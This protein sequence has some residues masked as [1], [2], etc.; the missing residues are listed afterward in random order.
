MPTKLPSSFAALAGALRKLLGRFDADSVT[1]QRALVRAL[2]V[3]PLP[4]GAALV[5]YHD[6]LLFLAAHPFD[7]AMAHDVER[8]M[9]RIERFLKSQPRGQAPVKAWEDQGMPWVD[10]VT[11]FSHDTTRW[12]LTHPMLDVGIECIDEPRASYNDVLAITLP[13]LERPLTTVGHERSDLLKALGVAPRDELRFVVDELARLDAQPLAK[14]H[15]HDAL[16]IFLRI[17]PRSAAFSKARNRL[18][19]GPQGLVHQRD[20]LRSFDVRALLDTPLPEPRAM[21]PAARDEVIRVL[22]DTMTLT[23]RETDPCTYLEPA[24]LRVWDLERGLAVAFFGMQPQRQMPLESYVGF[25]L[26]KNGLPVAYGGSWVFGARADFGMNIFEPYRGG[27]SGFMMAQL[28]RC[29]RQAFG[30]DYFE[31]DAHQFGLDNPDG[32][33]SGAYWFY[34]RHGFRSIDSALARLAEQEKR[35]ID[36]RPGYRSSEK[37]LLRFTGSNV[38]LRLGSA[39]TLPVGVHDIAAKVTAMIRRDHEG[40]RAKAEAACLA[41]LCREAGCAPPRDDGPDA[42]A[43]SQAALAACATRCGDQET[44]RLW[45]ASAAAK[46]KDLFAYQ[47]LVLRL[48]QRLDARA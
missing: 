5:T 6:A 1:H 4:R 27:E 23:I 15:L 44:W 11:R 10:I 13:A 12:L 2:A 33:A 46:S 28:L 32:I 26:F 16:G 41:R 24:S 20:K 22:R 45:A 29:Y 42:P 37:T 3:A 19:L 30:V 43:W 38:A 8:G 7:D 35:R 48:T 9:A 14:D 40:L 17:K 39:K 21:A 34:H 25:T 18:A 36:T 31:V 47:A